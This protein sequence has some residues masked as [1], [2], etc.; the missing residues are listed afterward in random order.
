[1]QIPGMTLQRQPTAPPSFKDHLHVE[2][3]RLL[4]DDGHYGN[5][6]DGVGKTQESWGGWRL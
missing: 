4:C 5:C 2:F 6:G 3:S 1:M